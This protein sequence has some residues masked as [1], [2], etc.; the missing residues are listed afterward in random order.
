MKKIYQIILFCAIGFALVSC[1]GNGSNSASVK[2]NA[3]E[4]DYKKACAEGDFAR[5][6]E[7]VEKMSD[8]DYKRRQAKHKAKEYVFNAEVKTLVIEN[9][10]EQLKPR[11]LLLL[12]DYAPTLGKPKAENGFA[13]TSNSY[14]DEKKKKCEDY[15]AQ[16]ERYNVKCLKVVDVLTIMGKI[17]IAEQ[18]ANMMLDVPS[19][20]NE[21]RVKLDRYEWSIKYH[22]TQ[23]QEALKKIATANSGGE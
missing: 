21:Y 22:D 1:G 19:W 12:S 10:D 3:E 17:G 18:I 4:T 2:Q 23:K 6:Y 15:Q 9:D 7:L 5:A 16:A 20:S 8:L 14:D 11:L 13:G